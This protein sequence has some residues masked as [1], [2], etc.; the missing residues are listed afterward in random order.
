[1]YLVRHYQTVVTD[2]QQ[3]AQGI[4]VAA[5]IFFLIAAIVV[6]IKCRI[7]V[8]AAATVAGT[9]K[10]YHATS[11]IVIIQLWLFHHDAKLQIIRNLCAK[12]HFFL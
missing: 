6:N 9:A 3:H 5:D 12:L 4:A 10:G 8:L 7:V 11:H 1:M 2:A